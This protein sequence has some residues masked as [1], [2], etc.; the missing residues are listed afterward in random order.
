MS[1]R[2]RDRIDVL[3]TPDGV[4]I[5]ARRRGWRTAPPL[6]TELATDGAAQGAAWR[7]ALEALA[8]WLTA[9]GPLRAE[10]RVVLSDHVVRYAVLPWHGELT[11]TAERQSL[12][13]HLFADK[14]GPA[15]Q[16]WWI[17]LA[18]PRYGQP[19]VAC[20]IDAALREGLVALAAQH[21]LTLVSLQPRLAMACEAFASR[22]GADAALFVYEPGRLS[23]AVARQGSWQ[24]IRS[25]R[26]GHGSWRDA[27]LTRE[28][29]VMNLP[30]ETPLFLVDCAGQV[31]L[32]EQAPYQLLSL[33]ERDRGA[34]AAGTRPAEAAP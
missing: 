5:A 8:Q 19:T 26:P 13:R 7:P 20:A 34:Q 14:Y 6:R 32:D 27:W 4:S 29:D 17:Q 9:R 1:P 18:A 22:L 3:L 33:R 31:T 11:S 10:L 12:V 28:V 16:D 24:A 30:V 21:R 2:W 23:C 15:S 25:V